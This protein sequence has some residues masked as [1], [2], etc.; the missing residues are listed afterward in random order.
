MGAFSR[1][2]PVSLLRADSRLGGTLEES[3]FPG[4][5]QAEHSQ[6][7]LTR[8]SLPPPPSCLLGP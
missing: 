5:L 8:F 6:C 4:Q 1:I 2:F 3:L 7:A